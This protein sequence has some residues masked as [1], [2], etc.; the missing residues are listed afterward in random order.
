VVAAIIVLDGQ[1]EFRKGV[2]TFVTMTA[3]LVML[4]DWLLS[5]GVTHVAME[6]TEENFEALLVN[7]RH[8]KPVPGR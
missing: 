8:I 2:R 7:T 1:G 4:S 5:F 6:S 3:D